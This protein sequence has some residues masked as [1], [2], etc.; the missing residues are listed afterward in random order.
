MM[1]G[2]KN[3]ERKVAAHVCPSLSDYTHRISER[4]KNVALVAQRASSM[5]DHLASGYTIIF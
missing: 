4:A 2:N 1:G 3:T 5:S